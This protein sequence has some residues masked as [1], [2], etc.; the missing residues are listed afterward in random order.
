MSKNRPGFEE[1][2]R[3]RLKDPRFRTEWERLEPGYQVAGLRIDR[4][5]TQTELAERVGTKQGSISRL[6]TGATG[7]DLAFLRRVVNALG[8]ELVVTIRE[9]DD[10]LRE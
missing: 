8:G 5:L 4:G 9:R 7:P 6:E 2:L 10:E 1:R 3:K